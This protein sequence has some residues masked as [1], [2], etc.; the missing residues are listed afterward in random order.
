VLIAQYLQLVLG[1]SPLHAGLWM[2]PGSIAVTAGSML[3]PLIVRRIH[4]AL[5]MGG[6]LG[7]ATLGFSVL[8]HV[9]DLGLAGLV[10]G[11]SLLYL[12]LGPVFT[13]GTELVVGAAPPERAGAA[14][15]LSETSSE[16][17]GA[18]G[19]AILG[20]VGTAIYRGAMSSITVEGV[21]ADAARTAGETLGNAAAIAQRL[22]AEVG[23]RLLAAAQGSFTHTLELI[24]AIC[25]VVAALTAIAAVTLLRKVGP[26]AHAEPDARDTRDACVSAP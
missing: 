24:A 2:L 7:L 21:S 20:S 18:L 25:A 11:C 9:G 17:G 13:L 26:G 12:G 15:A 4:P 19:I 6:G 1:L 14:A 5:V 10:T 16:L 3:A 23:D 22:P 8:T